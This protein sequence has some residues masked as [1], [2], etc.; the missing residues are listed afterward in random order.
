[1]FAAVVRLAF[2]NVTESKPF[3]VSVVSV[4]LPSVV[5]VAVAGDGAMQKAGRCWWDL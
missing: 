2:V 1:V 5:F 3:V 4:L